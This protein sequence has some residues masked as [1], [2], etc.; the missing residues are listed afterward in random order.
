MKCDDMMTEY[1]EISSQWD[2]INVHSH[3]INFTFTAYLHKVYFER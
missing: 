2:C 1:D 3:G